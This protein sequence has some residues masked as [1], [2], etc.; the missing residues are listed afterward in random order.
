[1]EEAIISCI[2]NEC[3][4]EV[5]ILTGENKG[6]RVLA[7]LSGEL[8]RKGARLVVGAKLRVNLE[9]QRYVIRDYN[10]VSPI[11]ALTSVG[12]YDYD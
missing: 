6:E 7:L 1:M 3:K 5:H 12:A 11:F 9:Q 10:Y 2:I 4:C 8:Q